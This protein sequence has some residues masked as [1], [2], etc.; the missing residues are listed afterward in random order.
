MRRRWR[1]TGGRARRW[2]RHLRRRRD[3]HDR[4]GRYDPLE[5]MHG[6]TTLIPY[7]EES[8]RLVDF[9]VVDEEPVCQG[10]IGIYGSILLEH[11]TELSDLSLGGDACILGVSEGALSFAPAP[12][13]RTFA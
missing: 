7:Q 8:G 1:A 12:I 9:A 3:L 4:R 13:D 11:S 5:V 10:V 2:R 6:G